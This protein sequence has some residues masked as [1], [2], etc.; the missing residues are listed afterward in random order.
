MDHFSPNVS[1]ITSVFRW[2]SSKEGKKRKL[3]SKEDGLKGCC[4]GRESS[5]FFGCT[6]ELAWSYLERVVSKERMR[7]AV[8]GVVGRADGKMGKL[9]I[10]QRPGCQGSDASLIGKRLVSKQTNPLSSL[11]PEFQLLWA[12]KHAEYGTYTE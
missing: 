12:C 11:L 2:F 9:H 7:V 8:G 4:R 6:C 10:P 5:G 3:H 1:G